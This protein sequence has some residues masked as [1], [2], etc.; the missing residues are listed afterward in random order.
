MWGPA[1]VSRP[2]FISLYAAWTRLSIGQVLT[3][4]HEGMQRRLACRQTVICSALHVSACVKSRSTTEST[5]LLSL[6][7]SLSSI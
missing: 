3:R 2:S 7:F 4:V 1:L 6:I 5:N